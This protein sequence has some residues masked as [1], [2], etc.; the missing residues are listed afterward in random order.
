MTKPRGGVK[1]GPWLERYRAPGSWVTGW[2]DSK[3]NCW[4][5]ESGITEYWDIG[6]AT[7]IQICGS[8]KELD[9]TVAAR[10]R[11]KSWHYWH[12]V[13]LRSGGWRTVDYICWLES[14]HAPVVY[15]WV[16]GWWV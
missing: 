2:V 14:F 1:R 7:H 8:T 5:C 10:S 4:A 16:E 13:D 15:V 6:C 11:D 12:S 3:L 9:G